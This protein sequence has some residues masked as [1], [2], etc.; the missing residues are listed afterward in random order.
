MLTKGQIIDRLA[1]DGAGGRSQVKHVL[2]SL[3]DLAAEE[4]AKGENFTVPGV[5]K[6]QWRYIAP[7]KKGESYKKGEEYN[8]FGT[9]KVAEHDSPARKQSIKLR[10]AL[11]GPIH[12]IGKDA[13]AGRKAISKAKKK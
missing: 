1:N 4:L 9:V 7:R 3:A 2:D 8:S 13:S 12:K 10:P 11:A 5:A 6:L